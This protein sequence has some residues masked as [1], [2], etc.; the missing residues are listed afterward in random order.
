MASKRIRYWVLRDTMSRK[1]FM[2]WTGIGPACC[3]KLEKA[4]KFRTKIEA[5]QSPASSFALTFFKP[6]AVRRR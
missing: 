5:L 1:Y 6:R 4:K 2:Q 3:A